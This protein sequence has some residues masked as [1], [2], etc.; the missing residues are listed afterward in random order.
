MLSCEHAIDRVP[1]RG[2]SAHAMKLEKGTNQ[3]LSCGGS[4]I[5]A[6]MT[7]TPA[8][9]TTPALFQVKR[10]LRGF[11]MSDDVDLLKCLASVQVITFVNA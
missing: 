11:R 8:P 9:R 2:V 3:Q 4:G 5:R 6:N 7:N 10:L 1:S